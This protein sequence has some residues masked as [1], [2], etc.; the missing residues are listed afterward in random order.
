[1]T[2][3]TFKLNYTLNV[4]E[5]CCDKDFQDA[6]EIYRRNIFRQEKTP[7][8][9]IAWVID[10]RKKFKTSMPFIMGIKL[11]N[12]II[13][14]SEIAFIPKIKSLIIDYI[15]FDAKYRTNSAFYSFLLLALE[16]INSLKIDYD[17]ILFEKVIK[18]DEEAFITEIS[19]LQLEG[20]QV[21]NQ[22][23]FQ[24][25]LDIDNVDSEQE[26]ILL[27]YQK[28]NSNPFI[29]K[30]SY[31]N[32]ISAI[33]FDYYFEWDSFFFKND[34]EKTENY[35]RLNLHIE[36]I[37]ETLKISQIKI[38]GYPFQSNSNENKIIPEERKTN[39]K[40]WK[41]LLFMITFFIIILAIILAVKKLN[42]ELAIVIVIF[43]FNI[44]IWLAFL[45][46]TE[47]RAMKLIQKIPFIS[48]FFGRTK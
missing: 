29:S 46:L 35:A 26:A 6:L 5:T 36:K 10:N 17:Y 11:N 47:D 41:A 28:N 48:K 32:M 23:Y 30:E 12:K 43:V 9:E 4:F 2:M 13:G 44:F 38:N 25:R 45:A 27:I 20:F 34:E 37:A 18:G 22:L 8:N 15:I 14:F 1:M 31:L 3:I 42:I 24:P 33:Y 7:T 40:I 39:K 16:Y 21:I 19:E